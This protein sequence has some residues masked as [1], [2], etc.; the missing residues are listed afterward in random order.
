MA[1]CNTGAELRQVSVLFCDLVG[2]TQLSD[3]LDPEELREIVR[4]Y[5]GVAGEIIHRYEG[6]VAQYLGDGL[7]I[8]F[9]YPH[10]H[11]DGARRA[12]S[13][14]LEIIEAVKGLNVRCPL[15]LPLA[16]RIGIHTGV[17]VAGDVGGPGKREQLVI[18][19]TPNIAARL[20][21]LAAP[22]TL[23]ISDSTG[24]LV[25][26]GFILESMGLQNLKGIEKPLEVLRVTR[27][28]SARE[29]F[30]QTRRRRFSPLVGRL[31]E[32]GVMHDRLERSRQ[33]LGQVLLLVAEA[34]VGKSRMVHTL[35]QCVQAENPTLIGRCLPYGQTR[36]LL[37]IVELFQS[38]L[39]FEQGATQARKLEQLR[40]FLS[41]EVGADALSL[42]LM[43]AFF[44]L[45]LP[46][47]LEPVSLTPHRMREQTRRLLIQL[48]LLRARKTPL[49]LVVEDLHWADP[50][51]L[52]FLDELIEAASSSPILTLLTARSSFQPRWMHRPYF[53]SLPLSRFEDEE[54]TRLVREMAGNRKLPEPVV[55]RILEQADGVPLFLE[56][57]TRATLESVQP[58]ESPSIPATLRD[59]LTARLDRLGP[60]KEVAQLASV[61]G[62]RF[63]HALLSAVSSMEPPF[64]R[65]HLD[66]LQSAGVILP[67]ESAGQAEGYK[68]KHVLIQEA[69]YESIL[70][71]RRRDMH[72]R[73]ARALESGFPEMVESH[74][75]LLARH[76]EEAGHG[77]KSARYLYRAGQHAMQ[78]AAYT[79][80]ISSFEHAL[81]LLSPLPMSPTR[82]FL[83]LELRI[84]LGGSLVVTRGYCAPEVER[85]AAR[86]R[87]L[88]AR[89]GN[90]PEVVPIL[91]NLWLV[92]LTGSRRASAQEQARQ[93]LDAARRY[94]GPLREVPAATA[95]ATTLFFLGRFD[96]ARTEFQRALELYSPAV[97][98]SLIRVYGEDPGLYALVYLQ[99]LYVLVGEVAQAHVLMERT[100]GLLEGLNDPLA[101]VHAYSYA[102]EIFVVLGEPERALEYARRS[103]ALSIEHGFPLWLAR[104]MMQ[105]GWARAMLGD[106]AKGLRELDKGLDHFAAI[107]QKLPLTY[108]LSL[109]ADVRLK[110]GD[111]ERGL[112]CIDQALAC[113]RTNL[114]RF[115]LPE[116]CRLKGELLHAR[117]APMPE[118]LKWLTKAV[119][120]ARESGAAWLE[121]KAAK[122]LA[123]LLDMRGRRERAREL[124]SRALGQIRGGETTRD[125]RE[126]LRLLE[127]LE[128][129]A[130]DYIA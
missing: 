38:L 92:S 30:E 26:G 47:G 57:L 111:F 74:P 76:H 125:Y 4:E 87:E 119:A 124:L 2:S 112:S 104:G 9:G 128:P 96:E 61:I 34:G 28:V 102:C 64:L 42:P 33:G 49:I 80:A 77:E 100:L 56:E 83:E 115:Y 78:R 89:R 68:F 65:R 14:G 16:V 69:A 1:A 24:R 41:R 126:A 21:G 97:R 36:A 62:R 52:E 130:K 107:Q 53:T 90:L 70:K 54:A 73:I 91:M 59:S 94:P 17:G 19:R 81:R 10:A 5:Q 51:T 120:R 25:E 63:S 108:Y 35:Q 118:V 46:A 84:S 109:S 3:K 101:E 13:A 72:A 103:T 40:E 116:L 45:L 106:T 20:Q 93:L 67:E 43:A 23:V 60:V 44:S 66:Q 123:V 48:L 122:S 117:G 85:N 82:D 105:E 99:W 32:F 50:S 29:R 121:L 37:P 113:A 8:Y 79:E 114:D 12:V 6:Y 39:G 15:V 7:L 11:E 18:G 22:D 127:R 75:E 27:E 110:T 98:P 71:T 129:A 58:G 31:A 95:Q 55:R 88:C 86:A